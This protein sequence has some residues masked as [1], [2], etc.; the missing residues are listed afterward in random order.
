MKQLADIST[1]ESLGVKTT[2]Q[3]SM[4]VFNERSTVYQS[5]NIS[6]DVVEEDNGN[7]TVHANVEGADS[8]VLLTTDDSQKAIKYVKSLMHRLDN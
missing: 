8:V 3:T 7:F 1:F 2:P 6:Y 5:P 4:E